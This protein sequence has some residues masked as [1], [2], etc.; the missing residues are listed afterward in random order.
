MVC[1]R[2]SWWSLPPGI[3]YSFLGTYGDCPPSLCL[4]GFPVSFLLKVR[5]KLFSSLSFSDD[6][7]W[8]PSYSFSPLPRSPPPQDSSAS[9][10]LPFREVLS[11]KPRTVRVLYLRYPSRHAGQDRRSLRKTV[12]SLSYFCANSHDALPPFHCLFALHRW[13]MTTL[14]DPSLNPFSRFFFL[15]SSF[16]PR[17]DLVLQTLRFTTLAPLPPTNPPRFGPGR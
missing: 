3:N 13:A 12:F 17:S 14:C 10:R 11:H 6:L 1:V 7:H 16:P 15:A 4:P 8:P 9:F 5:G 2:N